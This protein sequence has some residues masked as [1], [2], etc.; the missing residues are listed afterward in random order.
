MVAGRVSRPVPT[1]VYLREVDV[2]ALTMTNVTRYLAPLSVGILPRLVSCFFAV[3]VFAYLS[4]S[5]SPFPALELFSLRL[6]LSA[7]SPLFFFAYVCFK[8]E[9]ND[10]I[11]GW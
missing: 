4:R 10:S 3:L 8:M 9:T 6:S 11:D 2:S 7:S 1:G 5:T